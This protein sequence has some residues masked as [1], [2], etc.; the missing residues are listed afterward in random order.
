VHVALV[1]TLLVAAPGARH[2]AVR[3]PRDEIRA[4]V[5]RCVEAYGGKQALAR[6][7][8]TRQQGRV[9]S[10]LHPGQLGRIG[11]AYARP[12]KLRVETAFPNGTGEIRVLDGGHGWRDGE[13]VAGARLA[14]MV[15]QAARLDLPA[16]LA[17]SVAKLEDRGT[18]TV[19]GA[20][21]RVLALTA[22]PGLVVEADVEIA[23]GRVIRSRGSSRDPAIA[24]AFETTYGDFRK[25]DGVLVAFREQN[26]ANGR[27][28][29]ETVLEQVEFPRALP[30]VTFRP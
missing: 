22:A 20:P 26:W 29:G 13:E 30:D 17:S 10:L 15:L 18:G 5:R 2:A 28:T 24:L 9:T 23:T 19:D 21:V 3:T 14:A 7:A 8:I 4:L 16:L 27:T 1:L 11:R 12:G 25:V 6:A